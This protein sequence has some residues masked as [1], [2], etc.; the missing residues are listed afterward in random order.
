MEMCVVDAESCKI[1]FLNYLCDQALNLEPGRVEVEKTA[2]EIFFSDD[3]VKFTEMLNAWK[4]MRA[5]NAVK[6]K[7]MILQCDST[8]GDM[9]K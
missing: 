3:F 8:I 7:D 6:L 1:D 2:E 9:A 5:L 4:D